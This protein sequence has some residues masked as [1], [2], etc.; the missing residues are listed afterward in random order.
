MTVETHQ[1]GVRAQFSHV[2]AEACQRFAGAVLIAESLAFV[3]AMGQLV[4]DLPLPENPLEA[5]LVWTALREVTAHGAQAHHA[6]FH[7]R[8]ART[9]C[10]FRPP[11]VP[12]PDTFVVER[13]FLLLKDWAAAYARAFDARHDWPPAVRAA[14]VLQANHAGDWYVEALARTVNVSLA[15]LERS[16]SRTYGVTARQYHSLL[17]LRAVAQSARADAGCIEGLILEAGCRSNRAVY[18]PLR[19]LTGLTVADVRRLSDTEFCSLMNGPL[20]LPIAGLRPRTA[21]ADPSLN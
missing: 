3:T 17:R 6:W 9:P 21:V 7:D 8:L 5:L 4:V 19:R 11:P 13:T 16:F 20:A 10:D 2:V 14:Q 12:S 15:T 18:G 1:Y